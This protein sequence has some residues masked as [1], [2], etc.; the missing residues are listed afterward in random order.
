MKAELDH[1]YLIENLSYDPQTGLFT[2]L[3]NNGTR[4]RKGNIAGSNGPK[5][6][7][8]IKVGKS[9]YRAHRLAWFYMTKQW[10]TDQVDHI[11]RIRNDNRWCNLRDVNQ[12]QNS[13]NSKQRLSKSGIEG[14]R[15][16]NN[17]FTVAIGSNDSD[18]IYLGTYNTLEIAK[19]VYQEAKLDLLSNGNRKASDYVV[20]MML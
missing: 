19:A 18:R 11:N 13:R 4:A 20:G 1:N 16:T 10:P 6:Y 17:K 15:I 2:W 12:V 3:K 8:Q 7:A 5:G 14:I 9:I